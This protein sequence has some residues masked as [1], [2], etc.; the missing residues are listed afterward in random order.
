MG[1]GGGGLKPLAPS[2]LKPLAP[3]V[4][5]YIFVLRNE[6]SFHLFCAVITILIT[7]LITGDDTPSPQ[8]GS[9]KVDSDANDS[10]NNNPLISGE[11]EG[12][13]AEGGGEGKEEEGEKKMGEAD[14]EDPSTRSEGMVQFLLT[15]L[16]NLDSRLSNPVI[17]RNVPW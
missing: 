10:P 17:I 12:E 4:P 1:G 11:E 9:P 3:P 7:V 5:P 8:V 6:V 2:V 15:D 14:G 16:N 13:K